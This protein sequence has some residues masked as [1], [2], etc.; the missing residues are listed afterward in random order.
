[1]STEPK[2]MLIGPMTSF[3]NESQ[4]VCKEP[5]SGSTWWPGRRDGFLMAPTAVARTSGRPIV[6]RSENEKLLIGVVEEVIAAVVV[7]EPSGKPNASL[8]WSIQGRCLEFGSDGTPLY[9]AVPGASLEDQ[10]DHFVFKRSLEE[11]SLEEATSVEVNSKSGQGSHPI[12]KRSLILNTTSR[13]AGSIDQEYLEQI[14]NDFNRSL[15]HDDADEEATVNF[16][17]PIDVADLPLFD[18][19][20]FVNEEEGYKHLEADEGDLDNSDDFP[21]DFDIIYDKPSSGDSYVKASVL[22]VILVCSLLLSRSNLF[23]FPL[24]KTH[25]RNKIRTANKL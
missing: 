18:D 6:S 21:V 20:G 14:V 1:M 23:Y 22:L 3:E 9:V 25:H 16:D 17:D 2:F 10:G 4:G 13:V 5:A 19:E 24:S 7:V 12:F 11:K 8:W 15:T